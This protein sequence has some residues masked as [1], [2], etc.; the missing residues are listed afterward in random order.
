M[1]NSL[2]SA[3][4]Q[5]LASRGQVD[6]RA[7]DLITAE[8]GAAAQQS[9]P[10]L[11]DR[12]PDF[13]T[14]WQQI[15]DANAPSL[16]EEAGQALKSG[17]QELASTAAGV[18]ALVTNSDYLKGKARE[19]QADA[20]EN[21]PTIPTM[22]DVGSVKDAARYGI[23]KVAGAVPSLAEGV[24]LAAAG[25][26]AGTAL[27]PEGTVAGGIEG[28]I[29]GFLGKGIVKSAIRRLI[30]NDVLA[31]TTEE[32]VS[33]AI[34]AGDKGLLKVVQDEAA[35]IAAR[36]AG[37]AANALN[38]Y[39]LNA[40]ALYNET[41]NREVAALGGAVG[42]IPAIV[43]PEIVVHKLYP[44]VAAAVGQ[45]LGGQYVTRLATEALKDAGILGS[46][47]ALQE[48]SNLVSKNIADGKDPTDI[49]DADW[50]RIK[51]AAVGGALTGPLISP[52]TARGNADVFDPA[53]AQTRAQATRAAVAERAVAPVLPPE[54]APMETP[55]AVSPARRITRMTIEQKSARLADL[56]AREGTLTPDEQ[57]EAELLQ[58]F[59]KPPE[60]DIVAPPTV[61]PVAEVSAGLNPEF[62][63]EAQ[64]IQ[65]RVDASRAEASVPTDAPWKPSLGTGII[66]PGTEQPTPTIPEPD[67]AVLP[68][69]PPQVLSSARVS[70]EAQIPEFKTAADVLAYRQQQIDKTLAL[71]QREIG[72][73]PDE[74]R[75]LENIMARDGETDRFAKKLTPEKQVKLEW[76]FEESPFN[77][78]GN[79]E[80]APWE[81]DKGFDPGSISEN[82]ATPDLARG[83][84]QAIQFKGVEPKINS[85]RFLYA[86]LTARELE[87]RGATLSDVARELDQY[88]TRNA[89]SQGDKAYAFQ[90]VG[91]NLNDFL[92]SQG[93]KLEQGDLGAAATLPAPIEPALPPSDAQPAVAPPPSIPESPALEQRLRDELQRPQPFSFG[94]VDETAGTVDL[95]DN[96]RFSN[97]TGEEAS[98]FPV[99]NW[100]D[101]SGNRS[102]T[103]VAVVLEAPDGHYVKAGL[104]PPQEMASVGGAGERDTGPAV[105]GMAAETRKAGEYQKAVKENGN[106][107][108]LL[109]DL[110][111]AGYKVRALVH[112]DETPGRIFQRFDSRQAYDA[113][114]AATEKSTGTATQKVMPTFSASDAVQR[115]KVVAER[116]SIESQIDTLSK[117]LQGADPAESAD[118]NDQIR[119]LYRRMGELPEPRLMAEA[120]SQPPLPVE[121]NRTQQF[122]AA[123]AAARL[124]GVKIDVLMQGV[125]K[126]NIE[127]EITR[128]MDDLQNRYAAAGPDEQVSLQPRIE[129][130]QQQLDAVDRVRGIAYSPWHIALGLD[131]VQ[132]QN[133]TGM[134]AL[135]HEVGHT[136]LGRVDP[137][138]NARIIRAVNS[139]FADLTAE[140]AGLEAGTGVREA[141]LSDPEELLVSTM[142]QR[143]ATEG[144]PEAPSIARAVVQWVKDLY[145]RLA[146]GVQAA[147][148]R[149]PDPQLALDWFEN[150]LRRTLGGDYDYRF[151]GIFDRFQAE[152]PSQE[153]VRYERSGGT[154]SGVSDFYDALAGRVRQPQV[155][156]DTRESV[157]WN[158]KFMA[159][160]NDAGKELDIPSREANARI[161]AGSINELSSMVEKAYADIVPTVPGE[162]RMTFDEFWNLA[163]YGDT[164]ESRLADIEA[165]FPGA[166]AATIGGE[167]MTDPMN[168]G[169]RVEAKKLLNAFRD[170][171]VAKA[172]K[173]TE[174]GERAETDL[175]DQAKLLNK[176]EG[177]LRNAE[178]HESTFRDSL[179][180]MIRDMVKGVRRGLD[181]AFAAGGL[182][183]AVRDAEGL[184]ERDPIPP[185]YQRVFK[186]VMADE[187][188]VFN[189]LD[190]IAKLDLPLHEMTMAE[191]TSAIEDNAAGDSTLSQLMEPKNKPLRVALV[192]LAKK[193]SAQMD[194]I[195]MRAMRDPAAYLA[196]KA[197]LDE[198]RTANPSKFRELEKKIAEGRKAATF[199]DRIKQN[200]IKARA[201]L[202]RLQD[203]IKE[204]DSSKEILDKVRAAAVAKIDEFETGSLPAPAEWQ[205]YSG[206]TYPAM[207]QDKD[208]RWRATERR[209]EWT[210]EGPAKNAEQIMGDLVGNSEYLRENQARK[211][212]KQYQLVER[213]T[214]ELKMVDV[215]RKTPE[216]KRTWYEKFF[217]PSVKMLVSGGGRGA[218]EAERM[219]QRFQFIIGNKAWHADIELPAADWS[220]QLGR[221]ADAAGFKDRKAFL[222][223]IYEPAL[224]QIESNPGQDEGPALRDAVRT[225]RLRLTGDVKPEFDE[226]FKDFLRK[227]KVMSDKFLKVAEDSGIFVSDE[228]LGE[229]RHAVPR[230]AITVMRSFNA[231]TGSTILRDMENAGWKMIFKDAKT[232]TKSV[233]RLDQGTAAGQRVVGA[234]SFDGLYPDLANNEA[235]VQ[236]RTQVLESPES[237]SKAISGFFTPGVIQRW[238]EPF[239]NKPG[240]SAFQMRGEDIDPLDVQQAW[241]HAAGDVGKW[242]DD[243]GERVGLEKNVDLDDEMMLGDLSLEAQWRV[244]MLKNLDSLF[245]ME[246][247][248]AADSN[249][250]RG[251]FDATGRPPH[252]IM[253]SREN[254]L[255]PPEHI[256]H[257]AFDVDSSRSLLATLA[258]HAAFGRNG[259]A[260]NRAIA[261]IQS[262]LNARKSAFDTVVSKFS[263]KA[264]REEFAKTLG[265]D[266]K[267]LKR[268]AS[269][270]N[271]VQTGVGALKAQFG[272]NSS[273]SALND[274]RGGLQALHFIASL[275][276][277]NPKTGLLNFLQP[278]Q[279]A[280][281]RKSI[282][283]A[284]IRDTAG[285]YGQIAKS[286]L[287]QVLE[288]FGLHI[289]RGSEHAATIGDS[290][291]VAYGRQPW[292]VVAGVSAGRRGQDLPPAIKAMRSI[293]A[294]Q[295]RGRV[296][297]GESREFPPLQLL[298]LVNNVMHGM[299]LTAAISDGL[300]EANSIES[301]VNAAMQ[302]FAANPD[303]LADPTY[304]LTHEDIGQQSRTFA[305]DKAAFN[306]LRAKMV[307]Y[308]IGPLES[309][310][311]DAMER[312]TKGEPIL[313]KDQVLKA[314]QLA[315]NEVD[316]QPSINTN[317]ALWD[318]NPV[319][320]FASPLLGWPLR[321]MASIHESMRDAN[322]RASV[323]Q[324]MKTLGILATW[325][326]PL[327]LAFT[328]LT[329]QYDDKILKKK[330]NL[331][332]VDLTAAIPGVGPALALATSDKP[333][334]QHLVAMGQRLSRAGNIYG[335]AFD[336]ASQ[337]LSGADP[338]SGQR[339]FSMDGRI[340]AFSQILNLQQALSN[341]IESGFASTYANF[342][343]PLIQAL[344]GSGPLQAVDVIGNVLGI[345]NQE[346]RLVART[347]AG[348][349]LRAAGRETGLELRRA[350][351][352]SVAPTPMS[353]WTRE[354]YLAALGSD[355][356]NFQEN[357]R[358]AIDAA[359]EAGAPNPEQA[360]LESWKSRNPLDV[361]R[362]KPDDLAVQRMISIMSDNGA[363]SVRDA[364]RLFQQYTDLI[365]TS[366]ADRYEHR[367][368]QQVRRV[369]NVDQLRARMAAGS[370]GGFR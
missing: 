274:V 6:P 161:M 190:S 172:A 106:R 149:T 227:T 20:A 330:T 198:I 353:V 272:F 294:A 367:I 74:A 212:S 291:G 239:I 268:A 361:F 144:V 253:D 165:Q 337:M 98:Q 90:A 354:M 259:E 89:D 169:A 215:M 109:A 116:T 201:K 323:L 303:H 121:S 347:N 208:G 87:R 94:K 285:A 2:V 95:H 105:Q 210:P 162:D 34:A 107:P 118:I 46:A 146:M 200:A 316:L 148:G 33:S 188:P 249:Q 58:A 365:A 235:D 309:V 355:R 71:F 29:E 85:D 230:G 329:D 284:T 7:D 70:P 276:T 278:G 56:T 223:Q 352:G 99:E 243:L 263:S 45:K 49:S 176:I 69:N 175:V 344:V 312:Q 159:E 53:A 322:G 260:M 152:V 44:G 137:E 81:Y 194:L 38:M 15:R 151:A 205:P 79:T 238:L 248:T 16:T 122:A 141:N 270:Y 21:P 113:A 358:R 168:Q 298:P 22:A 301:V 339:Q 197:Q 369:P 126:A 68:E 341:W 277:N 184:A 247:R 93:I 108:A 114:Y 245:L 5:D 88:S 133:I 178:M 281:A 221:A 19:F 256:T 154:P 282:G 308:N 250:T 97:M 96:P 258:F 217:L 11:F 286:Y 86:V 63:K 76:F 84:V 321:Q 43:L 269:I 366:P 156:P 356:L 220:T 333:W 229:L 357:Y 234:A 189:Y 135:L 328:F 166:G 100:S 350:G 117:Q 331:G 317:P 138:M 288:A 251:L 54:V 211:G 292:T 23:A 300:S 179:K 214:N 40:G 318:T 213:V 123:T 326:M 26:A 77:K 158:L 170:R 10:T 206:E 132:K 55:A 193:E 314:T 171:V 119:Q 351:G 183:R 360:V 254:E 187:I 153:V 233:R 67:A 103:R 125:L 78:V 130:L 273:A 115:N 61:A 315:G 9:N 28:G 14:E 299:G 128:Q 185:E 267:E 181:T 59:V 293:S 3:Y 204:S 51:E 345:D 24:G 310:A 120:P 17:G 216:I 304:Q 177:N 246:S 261:D 275:V 338:T 244:E 39:G 241:Q 180:T 139:S 302:H 140:R 111:D 124:A 112:F 91:K 147:F 104:L 1:G 225:A 334:F 252:L 370:M 297:F 192:A 368:L 364:L 62:A 92:A 173:K 240:K 37:T 266:F 264:D 279:R 348:Q 35:G 257:A 134:V 36:R 47:M 327:G 305:M 232:D 42:A 182:A 207:A 226:L 4:R 73:S 27:G 342:E 265:Y 64:A 129:R 127:E 307:E 209:L 335:L 60:A 219:M 363:Q 80:W 346:M 202:R 362:T 311:R 13:K 290:Q 343:R 237:F 224:Y 359:R 325:S 145:Y 218:A 236:A 50:S 163:G 313:T 65:D 231:A 242:I 110:V 57:Q 324:A 31:G 195:Q 48:T 102:K 142:A 296:G 131:D 41:G 83:L 143:L 196:L 280:I 222:D 25:A 155:L 289:L 340:L 72:L 320:K 295:R 32:A 349:W 164:P 287:G 186:R 101:G 30:A 283:A 66:E 319:L 8:F 255:L 157:A 191:I 12:F 52:L 271:T 332:G 18:G 228:K 174:S 306:Y 136:I 262:G 203:T 160:D 336:A 150:Q 199:A 167:R 75:R 82:D